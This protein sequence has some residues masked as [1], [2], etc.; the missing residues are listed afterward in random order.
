MFFLVFV[1]CLPFVLCCLS[2]LSFPFLCCSSLS[3]C[4]GWPLCFSGVFVVLLCLLFWSTWVSLS[5]HLAFSAGCSCCSFWSLSRVCV[6]VC[7]SGLPVLF[8]FAVL[9]GFAVLTV[10]P[11]FLVVCA[12]CPCCSSGSFFFLCFFGLS[13]LPVPLWA[14]GWTFFSQSPLL[15]PVLLFWPTLLSTVCLPV[16]SVL[17]SLV[18]LFCLS[19]CLSVLSVPLSS[20]W[21]FC[22]V[23]PFL[24]FLGSLSCFP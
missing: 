22:S 12:F 10:L 6:C 24:F 9:D 5:P 18:F 17:F 16:V 11:V 20:F 19:H 13:V 4:S 14:S 2:N 1:S 8:V 15:C 3:F 23:W 21:S 7:A